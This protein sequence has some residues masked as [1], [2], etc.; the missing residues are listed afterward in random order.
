MVRPWHKKILPF[1]GRILVVFSVQPKP[2]LRHLND[3]S[4]GN[5]ANSKNNILFFHGNFV[6]SIFRLE[7]TDSLHCQS[8]PVPA[9]FG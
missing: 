7:K 4:G 3:E 8:T 2:S 5:L 9:P 6:C 1:S